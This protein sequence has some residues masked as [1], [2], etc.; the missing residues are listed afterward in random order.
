MNRENFNSTLSRSKRRRLRRERRLRE[1]Q[2]QKRAIKAKRL[3]KLTGWLGGGV[4]ILLGLGWLISNQKILPPKT[5]QGHIEAVP[6]AH[7]LTQPMDVRVHKHMLEHADGSGPPG[8]II[9]YNCQDFDCQPELL[10]KL[11]KLTEDYPVHLY[12]APY[13]NMSAKLVIT[14][15]GRQKVLE[16]F[17]EETIKNF[18]ER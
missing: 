2:K 12:V 4:V 13:P 18:I 11:K 7:F 3:I 16:S 17:D 5:D 1:Q 9:N 15:L 10:D 6:S 14:R 8:V